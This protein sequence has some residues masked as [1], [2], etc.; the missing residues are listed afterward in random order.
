MIPPLLTTSVVN[1]YHGYGWMRGPHVYVDEYDEGTLI[2]DIVDAS[3][4]A[5][6]WRGMAIDRVD[7]LASPEDKKETI[8]EAVGKMLELFPPP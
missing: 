2:L 8:R 5:I 6:I 3:S 4:R 1:N 7:F